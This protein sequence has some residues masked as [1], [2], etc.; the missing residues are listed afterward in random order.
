MLVVPL[1]PSDDGL[2]EKCISHNTKHLSQVY[3]TKSPSQTYMRWSSSRIRMPL[4][5]GVTRGYVP[6][7]HVATPSSMTAG[8]EILSDAQAPHLYGETPIPK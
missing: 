3:L 4:A 7:T 6:A 8:D 1:Q 2:C 5:H